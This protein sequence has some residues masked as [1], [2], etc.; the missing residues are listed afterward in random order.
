MVA[1]YTCV[2]LLA[3]VIFDNSPEYVIYANCC[4]DN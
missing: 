3:T 2:D 1:R 4:T